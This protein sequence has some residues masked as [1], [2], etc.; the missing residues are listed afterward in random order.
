MRTKACTRCKKDLPATTRYFYRQQTGLFNLKARCKNCER[1]LCHEY[2]RKLAR[3][4]STPR[5]RL[6]PLKLPAAC[7]LYS[8]GFE[9]G[10]IAN[11]LSASQP[12]VANSL[13]HWREEEFQRKARAA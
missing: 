1:Y 8:A 4:R 3:V 10:A 9:I 11:E 6:D 5:P 2:R 13:A 7:A 12:A